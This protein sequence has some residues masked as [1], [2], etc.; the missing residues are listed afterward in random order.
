LTF[1]VN[2]GTLNVRGVDADLSYRRGPWTLG[3]NI[4]YLDKY[5]QNP[6][7]GLP[8]RE[9]AGTAGAPNSALA[10]T[11]AKWRSMVSVSY[12]KEGLGLFLAAR[13]IGSAKR[14]TPKNTGLIYLDNKIKAQTYFDATAS[15]DIPAGGGEYSLFLTIN[16]L[17]DRKAPIIATTTIPGVIPQTMAGTYDILGRRF[18]AGIRFKI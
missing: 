13:T 14:D 2:Y 15:Y 16:N 7:G 3:V 1:P 5:E 12:E 6:G 11:Y 18:T 9:L 17:L 8:V 10:A 4:A